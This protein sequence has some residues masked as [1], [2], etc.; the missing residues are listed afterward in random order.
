MQ[1]LA[2]NNLGGYLWYTKKPLSRYQGWFS[3]LNGR[4]I[5]LIDS[6]EGETRVT[7]PPFHNGIIVE[8]KSSKVIKINFDIRQ[9]YDAPTWNR[10]YTFYEKGGILWVRYSLEP[11]VLGI[12]MQ[13]GHEIIGKWRECQYPFDQLRNS[14]PSVLWIYQGIALYTD[15]A[16]IAAGGS[17]EDVMAELTR[18]STWDGPHG[19]KIHKDPFKAATASLEALRVYNKEKEIMGLYAGLPWF[20]QFWLRDSAVSYKALSYS[21]KSE[22]LTLLAKE[23]LRMAGSSA[24]YYN[25]AGRPASFKG[26]DGKLLMQLRMKE[27]G[28][29]EPWHEYANSQFIMNGPKETWMDTI[30]REG[31]CIE[32]QAVKLALLRG[33]ELEYSFRQL[34]R[35]RFVVDGVLVDRVDKD[36]TPDLTKRPN[37]FLAAYLYPELLTNQ[38]WE[39]TFEAHLDALWLAWGGLSSLDIHDD[40][41]YPYHTGEADFR[42]VQTIPHSYHQGD[43]WLWIN[44]IA[45]IAMHRINPKKYYSYVKRIVSA[46]EKDIVSKGIPGH[47]SELSSA[48]RYEPGGSPVQLWSAA[49]YLELHKRL[50]S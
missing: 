35:D 50:T 16:F 38:E 1:F 43:S 27:F 24:A 29:R 20:F 5:K 49:T 25:L 30:S 8:G 14:L 7:L 18:L 33:N 42:G 41:F 45:A 36:G 12:K 39:R 6:F 23:G 11:V 44:N 13:G 19:G 2:T 31:A 4:I 47:A 3:A 22:V 40:H 15:R 17:E 21:Q 9:S 10:L 32:L 37:V 48:S 28:I 46:S 26:I 34:V